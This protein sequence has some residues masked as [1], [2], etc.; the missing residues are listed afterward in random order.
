MKS[1]LQYSK[2]ELKTLQV[3]LLKQYDEIK[4][5]NL[6]LDMSRGKPGKEQ[7]DM[8]EE[9]LTVVSNS[10]ECIFDGTDCR[11]YGVIDG[12]PAMK[13]IFADLLALKPENIIVGGNSSLTLMYDSVA[14]A[15]THGVFGGDKPWSQETGL[16][17]LCVVPGYDRH[18]AITEFF[19][20]ELIN[21]PMLADG[22]DMDMVE[23]L[24]GTDEK[25]KGIWCVPKYSNPDGIVYSDETIKRLANLK[26]LAKD[27][28]IF[29]DN[30]Y[31]VHHLTDDEIEIANIFDYAREC[32]NENMIYEFA[33]TSKYCFP[34]AGVSCIAASK[35][36]I[37]FIKKQ[38][39]FQT[40]GP[41]KMNQLRHIR[42]FKDLDGIKAHMRKQ[43]AVLKPK[44]DI[45][46]NTLNKELDGLEIGDWIEP[47]GGYFISF[48]TLEN[49]AKRTVALAKEAGITLTG[50][51]ATYPH[52]NDP[53]DRN[54]RI[55]PSYPSQA[56]LQAAIDVFCVCVKLA[57]V[58]KLLG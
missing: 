25:I 15:F 23:Q 51:G 42:Y 53:Q 39:F 58:E 26:P 4:A 11:N 33:S 18:F 40:I 56:D 24:V 12:I 28:R 3:D 45:V 52:K 34:G 22:P 29:Y 21:I 49:C 8:C 54:I 27:F 32:G 43:A 47:K 19:G 13:Q 1:Y 57:A 38:M 35:E 41:D 20:F 2:D 5:K 37:D 44:F 6:K 16:K 55:A 17:F 50:A 48:N 30:A 10:E 31:V 46:I 9:M 36:N 14:R 7:L